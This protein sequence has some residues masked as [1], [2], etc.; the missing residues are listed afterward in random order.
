MDAR[1][2]DTP[3]RR[4]DRKRMTDKKHIHNRPNRRTRRMIAKRRGVF[5]KPGMWDKVN[6]PYNEQD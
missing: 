5:G 2:I 6:R 3:D 4:D 1:M